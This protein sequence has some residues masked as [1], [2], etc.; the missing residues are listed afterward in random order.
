MKQPRI[1]FARSTPTS[2]GWLLLLTLAAA[3]L[4]GLWLAWQPLWWD[5]GYSFY[6]ATE[7]IQRMVALTAEDIHPPLYYALLHGWLL[8]GVDPLK[9]RLL[10]V[11][12]GALAIPLFVWLAAE[13]Y[14]A[15][16]R[17]QW[18]AAL[19]LLLNPLHL[20][21][22][23][24]VRMYGLAMLLGI[25]SALFLVRSVQRIESRQPALR[26]LLGYWIFATLSLYTL[27]YLGFLLL[28]QALWAIWRLRAR[29]KSGIPLLTTWLAIGISYL[30]WLIYAGLKLI[31][32]VKH[33]VAS[34]KDQPLTIVDFLVRHLS[35][36]VAGHDGE[37]SPLFRLESWLVLGL[38]GI[39][40]TFAIRNKLTSNTT[41]RATD[42]SLLWFSLLIPALCAFVVNQFSP[43]FPANGERLLLFILPY[44]L[45]ILAVA[46]DSCMQL[47]MAR[48]ALAGVL[49]L[50]VTGVVRFYT[51]PRYS[52][53]DYRPLIRQIVQQSTE[54]D[55]FLATFPWHVGFWR[56][57]A[58][59][60]LNNSAQPQ[61][62][63]D[64]SVEWDDNVQKVI[65]HAIQSGT[66][67]FPSLLSIGSTL[68][69]QVNNYLAQ[70]GA[71]NV[72]D[73]WFSE[74]TRLDGWRRNSDLPIQETQIDFGGLQSGGLQLNG[75]GVAPQQ[76]TSDNQP[77]DVR[78]RWTVSDPSRAINISLRLQDSGGQSWMQ[79]DTPLA[80]YWQSD[81][82]GFIKNIGLIVPP[83]LPPADYQLVISASDTASGES[84]AVKGDGQ[85]GKLFATLATIHIAAPENPPSPE[86]LPMQQQLQPPVNVQG[87][88]ILGYSAASQPLLAGEPFQV[89][90]F[91]QKQDQALRDFKL[92]VSLLDKSGNGVAGWEGWPLSNYPPADWGVG[93]LV[94]VPVLFDLPASVPS[95]SYRLVTGGID[96]VSGE[97][98]P[99]VELGSVAIHQRVASFAEVPPPHPLTPV[100]LVGSHAQLLGYD[101]ERTDQGV[102]V[103]LYWRVE[104]TLLPA[105]HIFVHFDSNDGKTVA[106]IDGPPITAQ[107][108]APSGS[109]QAGEMLVTLHQ[110][111][112]TVPA[113]DQIRVGL[114]NPQTDQR[115]PVAV[116]GMVVGDA[117]ELR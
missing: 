3:L 74:T 86:K 114:Y 50:A 97:K 82:K 26:P 51:L 70:S 77:V 103:R 2:T 1:S 75:V 55:T 46:I 81:S 14:P 18:I 48:L 64:I 22:S 49:A 24:E 90:L 89:R 107:G 93:A 25:G 10:S 42:H 57:Y 78:L 116:G 58:S 76:V 16:K 79:H 68:P 19:L 110:L 47:W 15:R 104:Q 105:H 106:Q 60:S 6:F 109:W 66:I 96:T 54:K 33:K 92:F 43:F 38:L 32:Y 65:E 72:A 63:S 59:E 29:W 115:L 100:P 108:A 27:Y 34:D 4:R 44:F 84:L 52:A 5:E 41:H 111:T 67:W 73:H 7:P 30:P 102:L 99:W 23:Q 98:S 28:A 17:M 37:N 83:G 13:L 36:L 8:A 95:G 88:A 101:V 80:S 31:S 40:I 69:A 9:G 85:E 45:L 91:Y 61:L 112:G 39:I 94:Q 71:L 21:Y 12:I 35:A 117:I 53:D 11:L 62:L 87:L 20:Y 56:A 113:Y